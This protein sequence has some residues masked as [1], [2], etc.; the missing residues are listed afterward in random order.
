MYQAYLGDC[1]EG[2]NTEDENQAVQSEEGEMNCQ[3]CVYG[4]I[5]TKY[6]F[7][8]LNCSRVF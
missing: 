6:S 4:K 2:Q 5:E 8:R 3:I 1:K 7:I